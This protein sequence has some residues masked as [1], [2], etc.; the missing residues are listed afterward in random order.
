MNNQ[1]K[2]CRQTPT[3]AG[4]QTIDLPQPIDSVTLPKMTPLVK[5]NIEK[6]ASLTD[7]SLLK[8]FKQL[9]SARRSW[10]SRNRRRNQAE[11]DAVALL[12]LKRGLLKW[13]L[14]TGRFSY[15]GREFST[16]MAAPNEETAIDWAFTGSEISYASLKAEELPIAFLSL[17]VV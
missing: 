6:Y 1:Q 4:N 12:C 17:E 10:N 13:W 2:E 9:R 8:K 3:S 7:E 14:I 16:Q 11:L 5:Q 15:S